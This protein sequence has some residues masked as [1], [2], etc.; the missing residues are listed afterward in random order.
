MNY[1]QRT[2]EKCHQRENELSKSVK[3]FLINFFLLQ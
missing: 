2:N 1:Q 3:K